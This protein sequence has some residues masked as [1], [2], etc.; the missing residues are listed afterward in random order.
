MTER[1]KDVG[2]QPACSL[3]FYEQKANEC[4]FATVAMLAGVDYEEVRRE[5]SKRFG[6]TVGKLK[7]ASRKYSTRKLVP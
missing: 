7:H 1:E 2:L 4:Q 6:I 3:R 5:A